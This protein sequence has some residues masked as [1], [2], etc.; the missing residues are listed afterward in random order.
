[1]IKLLEGGNYTKKGY[2]Y[3]IYI[4][5]PRYES[6]KTVNMFKSEHISKK[7]TLNTGFSLTSNNI[8]SNIKLELF[9]FGLGLEIQSKS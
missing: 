6:D 8:Y 2:Y 7:L 9:G 4:T 3:S 1:M 5:L